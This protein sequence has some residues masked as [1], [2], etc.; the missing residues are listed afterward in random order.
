MTNNIQTQKPMPKPSSDIDLQAVTTFPH[1]SSDYMSDRIRNKFRTFSYVTDEKGEVVR[2][3]DGNPRVQVQ[4][5]HWA[6]MEIFTQD[7]RLGNMNKDE[8]AFTRFH[9]DLCTDILTAMPESFHKPALITLERAIAVT[10]T[11]QSKGGFLRRMFN[12]FFQKSSVKEETPQKRSFFG[13]G[14]KRSTE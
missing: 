9:I 10:E 2:D 5:D 1:I 7:F 12:T 11:S 13:L 8:S 3:E 4:R 14:K 6:N